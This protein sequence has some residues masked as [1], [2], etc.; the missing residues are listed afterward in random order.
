MPTTSRPL[1]SRANRKGEHTSRVLPF[2][3]DLQLAQ[4]PEAQVAV[5]Q[6]T[7]G[8]LTINPTSG[9][10]AVVVAMIVVLIIVMHVRLVPAL[11]T[12]NV[13]AVNPMMGA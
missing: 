4:L 1:I 3:V 12:A 10:S 6:A 7:D 13:F 11:L 5:V 9:L 8:W 2:E